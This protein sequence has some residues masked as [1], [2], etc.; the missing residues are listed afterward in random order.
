MGN[1]NVQ[2]KSGI[3][4]TRFDTKI[5]IFKFTYKV[6]WCRFENFKCSRS[7]QKI[8]WKRRILNPDNSRVIYPWNY[9]LLS[10]L[11]FNVFYC[12]CTFLN[13][14]FI[15]LGCTYFKNISCNEKPSYHFYVKTKISVDFRICISIPSIMTVLHFATCQVACTCY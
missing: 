7:Y 1:V 12:S 3:F 5:R 14:H 6:N 15:Y 10:R 8:P 4:K 2:D 11:L 9:W 13:K